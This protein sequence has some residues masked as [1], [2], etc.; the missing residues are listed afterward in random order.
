MSDAP[1]QTLTCGC[2]V[3]T[4]RDFL[5]RTVGTVRTRGADCAR[6][7]HRPGHVLL[8]PGREHAGSAGLSA[9]GEEDPPK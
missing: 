5:G 7:D 3:E 6:D 9:R 4:R 2:E 8:M 1:T